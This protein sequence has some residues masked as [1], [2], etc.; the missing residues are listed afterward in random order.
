MPHVVGVACAGNKGRCEEGGRC[1]G[2]CRRIHS[3]QSTRG[4]VST[5]DFKPSLAMLAL[6]NAACTFNGTAWLPGSSY[7]AGH[8]RL[9]RFTCHV[10]VKCDSYF[11]VSPLCGPSGFDSWRCSCCCFSLPAG[12]D[13]YPHVHRSCLHASVLNKISCQT[14]RNDMLPY[15][16]TCGRA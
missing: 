8:L 13:S 4:A 10:V 2:R 11:W 14:D 15:M 5:I 12:L 6:R 1:A 7:M 3:R 9:G 16:I